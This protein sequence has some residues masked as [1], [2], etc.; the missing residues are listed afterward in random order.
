MGLRQHQPSPVEEEE[1]TLRKKV[2]FKA[3]K[4]IQGKPFKPAI[5][6][7]KHTETQEFSLNTER[8]AV[9][10]KEFDELLKQKEIE[11]QV[12]NETVKIYPSI[13]WLTL[14]SYFPAYFHIVLFLL[15]CSIC[16]Y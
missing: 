6:N 4:V 9:E 5:E 3:N 12:R 2:E 16:R 14:F 13:Y 10:R 8:R 1:K 11:I 7:K 15:L